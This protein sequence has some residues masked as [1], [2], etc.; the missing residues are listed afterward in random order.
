MQRLLDAKTAIDLT[1]IRGERD[2]GKQEE[3]EK[4]QERTGGHWTPIGLRN[5]SVSN[6]L[7]LS[8]NCIVVLI[9]KKTYTDT[10]EDQAMLKLSWVEVQVF[11][12][13]FL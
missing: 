6:K 5:K 3:R 2:Q 7:V 8:Y 13:T 11:T 12:V 1:I 9:D 4:L 10:L